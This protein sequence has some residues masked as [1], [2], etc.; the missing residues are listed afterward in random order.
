MIAITLDENFRDFLCPPLQML[1]L[2]QLDNFSYEH[3]C[4]ML[5]MMMT[6]VTTGLYT[7]RYK[8]IGRR[9]YDAR[10]DGQLPRV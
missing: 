5:M 8:D 1:L 7:A 9:P 2:L 4:T 6:M 3:F 10:V